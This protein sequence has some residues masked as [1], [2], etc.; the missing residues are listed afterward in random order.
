MS[1]N[2]DESDPLWNPTPG[3]SSIYTT[4]Q[5]IQPV[6]NPTV[7]LP[8]SMLNRAEIFTSADDQF[9]GGE[10]TTFPFTEAPPSPIQKTSS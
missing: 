10:A 1:H 4:L 8:L 3:N 5:P 6:D 9:D 2:N 7:D